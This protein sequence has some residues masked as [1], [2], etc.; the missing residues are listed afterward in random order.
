MDQIK[1]KQQRQVT[2]G[3]E[4]AEN[5]EGSTNYVHQSTKARKKE[6]VQFLNIFLLRATV[7]YKERDQLQWL[8]STPPQRSVY[9][10]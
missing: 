9:T 5:A 3:S 7:S 1:L 8:I 2:G 10:K 4:P 6:K